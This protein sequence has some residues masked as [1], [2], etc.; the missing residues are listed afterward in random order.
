MASWLLRRSG[1]CVGLI[2]DVLNWRADTIYH[3]GIGQEYQ[4]TDVLT[5]EWPGV[6]WVGFE[7]HPKLVQWAREK[8]YPG[9]IHEVA[10][11]TKIG[12]GILYSR[13]RHKDGSSMHLDR[14]TEEGV[15]YSKI[16]VK[17]DTLDRL[18]P[19]PSSGRNMLWLDCEG[20]ELGAMKGGVNLMKSVQMINIEM[21][22]NPSGDSWCSPNDVHAFL[23]EHGFKRQWIHTS[24]THMGQ[25]DGVYVKPSIFK[26]QYCCCPCMNK[27]TEIKGMSC[28]KSFT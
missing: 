1:I 20:S 25:Y 23:V 11:G 10:V 26:P 28:V 3:V 9:V 27:Q 6:K 24:R 17:L 15:N 18:I 19:Q 7:P 16:T 8:N 14:N 13:H 22:A 21:T 4:E 5:K 2:A 12:E